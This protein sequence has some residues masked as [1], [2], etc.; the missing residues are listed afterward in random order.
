[1]R[2]SGTVQSPTSGRPKAAPS[3]AAYVLRKHSG[4]EQDSGRSVAED[5]GEAVLRTGRPGGEGSP[6][7]PAAQGRGKADVRKDQGQ[8]R[9]Q[10]LP[11]TALKARKGSGR[12]PAGFMVGLGSTRYPFIDIFKKLCPLLVQLEYEQERDTWKLEV[13]PGW[14]A[15]LGPPRYPSTKARTALPHRRFLTGEVQKVVRYLHE[16]EKFMVSFGPQ[17]HCLLGSQIPFKKITRH[18]NSNLPHP[19]P[20][21]YPMVLS[22]S[23]EMKGASAPHI[24]RA[25]A[26]SSGVPSRCQ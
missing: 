25:A 18:M 22:H 2:W 16:S 1:M 12:G 20:F 15:H 5:T 4:T 14:S 7:G 24:S 19:G 26:L 3:P 17:R 21:L 6:Y 23:S 11:R 9:T 13:F 8:A 10:P